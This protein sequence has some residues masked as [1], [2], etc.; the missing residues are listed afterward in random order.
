MVEKLAIVDLTQYNLRHNY[1]VAQEML[2]ILKDMH[3]NTNLTLSEAR[4]QAAEAIGKIGVN[5][6]TRHFLAKNL[7]RREDDGSFE[8]RLNLDTMRLNIID[9]FNFPQQNLV[10]AS[11]NGEVLFVGGRNS[12]FIPKTDEGQERIRENLPRARVEF[13]ENAG[14]FPHLDQTD[15]FIKIVRKFFNS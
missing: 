2:Q 7:S 5:E 9:V 14:H 3:F 4:Y 13:I 11:F 15:A 1:K 10:N 6:E 8:W 12:K